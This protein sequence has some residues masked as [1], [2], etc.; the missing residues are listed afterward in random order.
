[1]DIE[2][3][4]H[5]DYVDRARSDQQYSMLDGLDVFLEFL[6]REGLPSTFFCT[7][8]IA[9][10]LA[11]RLREMAA[12]GHEIASHTHTHRRPLRLTPQEFELELARSKGDLEA[13]L[14]APVEGFRAPCFSLDDRGLDQVRGAG[15]RYDSSRIGFRGH[16]LYGTLRLQG[17]RTIRPFVHEDA[18]FYEFELPT[19]PMAGRSV[20]VSGGGYLR[21]FPWWLM[22]RLLR[23]FLATSDIYFLYIHPFELSRRPAPP[24]PPGLGYLGDR[25]FRTGLGGVERKLEL[26][27]AL[28]RSRG[29]SFTTFRDLRRAHMA[30]T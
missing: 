13:L 10:P 18:G 2:D 20:P 16:A 28:L 22:Q 26:L 17:Y 5:L 25:R 14:G 30:S 24:R 1:M 11:P 8:D 23:S 27:V 19:L 12:A 21:I 15:F 9:A 29:F 3:W 4:Y 6:G 7:G